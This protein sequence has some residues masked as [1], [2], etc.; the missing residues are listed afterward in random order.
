MYHLYP[1]LRLVPI[2]SLVFAVGL[3]ASAAGES[4]DEIVNSVGIKLR[5]IP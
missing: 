4:Q 5:L 1:F 2:A 3:H